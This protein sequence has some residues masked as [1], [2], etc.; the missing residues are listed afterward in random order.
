MFKVL[1]H[2]RHPKAYFPALRNV[3]EVAIKS[4]NGRET[5]WS[6]DYR[7]KRAKQSAGH[8]AKKLVSQLKYSTI[9]VLD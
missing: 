1:V 7:G 6:K 4:D 8:L 2:R 3:W 9:I 5:M